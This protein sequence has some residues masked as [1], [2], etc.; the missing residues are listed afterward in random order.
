MAYYTL[1]AAAAAVFIISLFLG[2]RCKLFDT[3]EE[4]SHSVITFLGML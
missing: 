4:L 1:A 3:C 2:Q